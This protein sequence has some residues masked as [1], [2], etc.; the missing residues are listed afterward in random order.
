MIDE[1]IVS[2]LRSVDQGG[3]IDV[4]DRRPNQSTNRLIHDIID[5]DNDISWEQTAPNLVAE[6]TET[7]G[8]DKGEFTIEVLKKMGTHYG[9]W[10][11]FSY[12]LGA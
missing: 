2:L 8:D 7:L 3:T 9:K 6:L 4:N 5:I 10:K 11:R 12:K 1:E